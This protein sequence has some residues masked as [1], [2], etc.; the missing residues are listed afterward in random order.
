MKR[1]FIIFIIAAVVIIF[2]ACLILQCNF[3]KVNDLPDI[4]KV[5]RLSV[6]IESGEH[7]FTRDSAKVYGF[8]YD[9]IKAFSNSIGVELLVINEGNIKDG[10][11]E[12]N[13][14]RCD[15][16]VSLRP[17][18]SD[19]AIAAVSLKTIIST[20]LMLVQKKDSSGKIMI[21]QQFELD[22]DTVFVIPQSGYEQRINE[23]S[24][25]LA[26]EIFVQEMPV[27]CPDVLIKK[28]SEGKIKYSI[29]P[30]YLA[31]KFLERYPDIDISLPLSFSEDLSWVVNKESVQLKEK[32]NLFLQDY[33][34]SPAFVELYKKYF[35]LN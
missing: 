12:L 9:I 21:N 33:I 25:E 27:T 28:V 22:K 3:G 29:C 16:L 24:N 8:Q 2:L 13:K 32:L 14:G 15:V 7:G 5:G 18:I 4:Q 20:R 23:L 10:I 11:E 26:A 31:P 1:I 6:L 17:L 30:E 35:I 19:T 34:G